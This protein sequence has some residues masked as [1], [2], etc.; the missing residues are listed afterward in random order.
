MNLIDQNFLEA[1][2][3]MFY[4]TW[5][6]VLPAAFYF[7]F[8]ELWKDFVAFFSK[9]SW[10]NVKKW[11]MVEVIPPREIEKGP[12]MMESFFSGIAAVLTTYNT[13]DE[14]LKGAFWHDR[15]GLELVGEEG[16]IHFYFRFETK[17]RNM[18]EA[19]IYAQYPDAE[20]IE[21]EDYYQR[22]PKVVPNK[23]WDL[24][25]TD[26]EFTAPNIYPIKT[27]DKFEESVTGEMIDPMAAMCEV[28]GTL[29]PGQHIW[30]Q[31]ILQPLPEPWKKAKSQQQIL[32]KLTGRE[33]TDSA[34]ALGHLGEVFSNI[35]SGMFGAVE[36]KKTEK[37]EQA[38]LEFRLTPVEKD[39]LKAVEEKLGK[40]VFL[41]KVRM[42][43]LA[44]RENFEKSK[45]S[46]FMGT[47]KQFSDINMNQIKPEDITKTYGKIFFIKRMEA[48]RK[49]KIWARYKTRNMDGPKIVLS[50][51]ELASLFHFPDM[52]VKSP[53]VPRTASKLGSAPS[54]LPIQ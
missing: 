35:F 7:I 9:T 48:F 19:Q 8:K 28:L 15:F 5:W 13:F 21:V 40:N 11:T 53:A 43:V 23:N 32:D 39:V 25:G 31:Y 10:Y 20:I 47:I 17:H 54:N 30:L 52:G 50:T 16:K 45:I 2:G 41:S 3:K 26:M 46:A 38:P 51:K 1:A 12:K 33:K 27:Y 14:Y 18:I 34:G 24:W 42:I 37:K 29:G 36:F 49:R 22:F 6:I 44:K 4:H